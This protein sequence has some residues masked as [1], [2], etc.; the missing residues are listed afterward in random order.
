MFKWISQKRQK[1]V[2]LHMLGGLGNNMFQY[3]AGYTYAKLHNRKLYIY[4]QNTKFP[5]TFRTKAPYILKPK[6]CHPYIENANYYFRDTMHLNDFDYLIGNF[7][8]AGIFNKYKKELLKIFTIR[9]A[10][11]RKENMAYASKIKKT[12][13]VSIHIRRTDYLTTFPKSI[14]SVQYYNNAI[15]YIKTQVHNPHFFIFSDDINWVISNLPMGDTPHTFVT[16]NQ[17]PESA[18]CD[19]YLMSLCKHNI[20]ANSSFSWWGTWLNRNPNKI[21]VS[22]DKWIIDSEQ[23]YN[24]T[25]RLIQDSWVKISSCFEEN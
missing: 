19:M 13:S 23:H 12:N 6:P 11:N 9:P 7:Q 2:G 10:T 1:P 22:P 5:E 4:N 20:I 21:V 24:V 14:L 18:A 3:A 8:D 25:K 15:N 17:T 16:C